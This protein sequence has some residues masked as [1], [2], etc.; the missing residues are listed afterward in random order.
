MISN[1]K[2]KFLILILFL[3]LIFIP[4]CLPDSGGILDGI[5]FPKVSVSGKSQIE[6]LESFLA[7]AKVTPE[8]K[9]ADEFIWESSNPSVLDVTDEGYVT[10]ISTGTASVIAKCTENDSVYGRLYFKVIKK[11]IQY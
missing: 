7:T 1:V 9:Y 8:G 3:L 6:L 4:G 5:I 10:G 11:S 2:K